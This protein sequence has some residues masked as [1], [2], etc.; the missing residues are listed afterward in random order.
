M[1]ACEKIVDGSPLNIGRD[2]R[3]TINATAELIFELTNWRPKKIH[4]D[5][6][7]PQGVASRAADLT[8]AERL[9]KWRPKV[10]YKEGFMKTID[11]YFSNKKEDDIRKN[12]ERLLFER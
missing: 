9:L 7:K 1:L 6:T 2:D 5:L 10:S 3:I 8:R 11:W 4:Y 12:F